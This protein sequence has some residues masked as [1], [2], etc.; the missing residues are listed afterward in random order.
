MTTATTPHALPTVLIHQD[1][2]EHVDG[3]KLAVASIRS[4][5][6]DLPVEVSCPDAT[7]ELLHWLTRQGVRAE[8][9]GR[10]AGLGWNVKPKLLMSALDK[11]HSRVMWVDADVV[12]AGRPARAM[13]VPESVFVATEEF[14]LGQDQGSRPRTTGWGLRP[15]RDQPTTVNSGVLMVSSHHRDLLER[16]DELLGSDAYAAA[17]RRPAMERPLH[18]VSDQDVLTALLGSEDF[19]DTKVHLLRRGLD[20]AQCAGP[21]GFTPQERLATLCGS[22]PALYHSVG[23][24]PWQHGASWRYGSTRR[25]RARA[26]YEDLH[27]RLSPYTAVARRFAPAA[28][29]SLKAAPRHSV[30]TWLGTRWPELPE[31]PLAVMDMSVRRMRRV[32]RISRYA[33]A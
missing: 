30:V 11:G 22:S 31:L 17:Q 19:A 9:D 18:M 6:P 12:V 15:G 26:R 5:C 2:P 20:I 28:G 14:S 25:S 4:S 8:S 10:F 33:R 13:S 7:P 24:K 32:L 29:I 23:V 27:L 16:W 3:L 1:R 21:A